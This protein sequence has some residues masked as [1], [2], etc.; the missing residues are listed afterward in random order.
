MLAVVGILAAILTWY[1][2]DDPDPAPPPTDSDITIDFPG[3]PAATKPLLLYSGRLG[4]DCVE[5]QSIV[6][7]PTVVLDD[8][9][10]DATCKVEIDVFAPDLGAFA[11]NVDPA[12][13]GSEVWLTN[14]IASGSLSITLPPLLRVPVR[15]W[16][17]GASPDMAAIQLVRQKQLNKAFPILGALAT[18]LTMDT[19]SAVLGSLGVVPKCENAAAIASNLTIYDPSR[20]NVYLVN[21]YN[22][23]PSSTYGYNC[24]EFNH[25]EIVFIAWGNSF[26]PPTTL[27]HELSHGM[28]LV[29]PNF[30]HTLGEADFTN[31]N[32][33]AGA[34]DVKDIRIGQLYNLNFSKLSWLN[35]TGSPFAQP[36]QQDCQD[37]WY[38]G[39]CPALVMQHAG[40]P[41]P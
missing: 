27:I 13:A 41:P 12:V 3:T 34:P 19:S 25:P 31:W 36:V 2:N 37:S 23:S 7:N 17:V 40:W 33:M 4:S 35:R 39:V 8:V 26:L 32:L 14:A 22:N 20:I 29:R 30:G 28:G 38:N 21:G 9:S 6:A 10:F 16:L 24:F 5:Y 11:R 15:L 1:V 18:G